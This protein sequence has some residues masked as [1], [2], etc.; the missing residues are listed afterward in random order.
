MRL[1][2]I[3]CAYIEVMLSCCL[4]IIHILRSTET[5]KVVARK[6][7]SAIQATFK[8]RETPIAL[9]IQVDRK[10]KI[11]KKITS[12]EIYQIANDLS[13]LRAGVMAQ[14]SNIIK[15]GKNHPKK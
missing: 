10:K 1:P 4:I 13:A 5:H 11:T 12:K 2:A 9:A 6:V 7:T 3:L 15:L 8:R 14:R